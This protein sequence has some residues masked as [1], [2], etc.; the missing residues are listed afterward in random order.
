MK[1]SRSIQSIFSDL[2]RLSKNET[3]KRKLSFKFES[4]FLNYQPHLKDF[5]SKHYKIFDELAFKLDLQGSINDLFGGEVVN[6]TENRPALHHQYRINQ[7]SQEFNF[8]KITEPFIQRIKKGGFK[9]I[10][11]FGIGGSYEGPK[12]LQEFTKHQSSRFNYYF[13]S[14]P[15]KDEFNSILKPLRGQKNFYIF[16]SKSLSTDETLSCLR[17]LGN[18][19]NSTNSL[20]ITANLK[21]AITLGFQENCI[22]PFPETVGGRYSIWSPIS[23]SVALDNKFSTFLKGGFSA[24][25]MLLGTSKKDREYQ[26]FIKILAYSDL[27]FSNFKNKKNRVVLSYNWKLR[28]LANYIQQ[29]EMESLGKQAN[30]RSIFQHTGQSIFGGFGS[31]AQHSYFQLLHQGTAEFCADIIYHPAKGSPLSSAQ[32][33][34]QANLL[35]VPSNFKSDPKEHTNSNS[36]VNLFMLPSMKLSSLGFLIASWEHRVFITSSMLQI[37]PFDQFGVKAGKIAAK[38]LLN[39]S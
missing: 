39:Q 1:N 2:K 22:V 16:S 24:D 38:S 29:L 8:K 15:D 4:E 34:G 25:K 3:P 14:G 27:W 21:K 23:L 19:R 5:S 37:N 36:P 13:V 28:S 7:Q 18:D 20:V 12:L 6:N 30:P 31:T 11:T 26:K 9:N 33:I 17:W 35:A 32:A 10:I